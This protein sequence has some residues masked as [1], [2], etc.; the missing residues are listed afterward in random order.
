MTAGAEASRLQVGAKTVRDHASDD[1]VACGHVECDRPLG[2]VALLC[3]ADDPVA[4]DLVEMAAQHANAQAA[5]G[6]GTVLSR[7]A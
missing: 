6:S 3:P 5:I 1:I 7:T 4:M 2:T